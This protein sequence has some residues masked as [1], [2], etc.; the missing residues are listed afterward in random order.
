[1][2]FVFSFCVDYVFCF[3]CLCRIISIT[4][5]SLVC[6]YLL[7]IAYTLSTQ[8]L[9][10]LCSANSSIWFLQSFMYDTRSVRA[11][12]NISIINIY[13]MFVNNAFH[14]SCDYPGQDKRCTI[15]WMVISS[16]SSSNFK[17]TRIFPFLV[18]PPP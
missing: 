9:Y 13:N 3:G 10:T 7:N 14:T 12:E 2:H 11:T 6:L 18:E 15:I 8:K 4:A 16:H 17:A 1:M 5:F